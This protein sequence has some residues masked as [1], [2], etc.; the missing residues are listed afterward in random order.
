MQVLL[1]NNINDQSSKMTFING[2]LK[3][4]R[5]RHLEKDIPHRNKIGGIEKRSP[6]GF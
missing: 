6:I 2:T 1:N 4:K 3:K 5:K